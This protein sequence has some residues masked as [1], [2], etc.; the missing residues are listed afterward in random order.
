MSPINLLLEQLKHYLIRCR[1]CDQAVQTVNGFITC[2]QCDI[3][4][5]LEEAQDEIDV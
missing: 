3:D 4:Y 1:Y 5:T 2:T